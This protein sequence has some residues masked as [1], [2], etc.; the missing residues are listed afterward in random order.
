MLTA[1]G[2]E[3]LAAEA[4]QAGASDYYPKSAIS[5]EILG[6]AIHKS[7]QRS[8]LAN[9]LN[10]A[11]QVI[12]TLAAAVEAKDPTTQG[13]LQRLAFYSVRVG[14]AMNLAEHQ[15]EILR[16]GGIL[17]D[18][19]KMGV[20]E[21]ILR[22]PSSLNDT[23]WEEMRKHPAIGESICT[24]LR[25]ALEVN[26][27]I[28]HHHERWDGGGYPDRLREAEIPLG[29]RIVCAADA[30]DAMATDRPYRNALPVERIISELSAGAGKQF[31]PDVA[32]VL[33]EMISAGTLDYRQAEAALPLPAAIR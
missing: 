7:L 21:S 26:P 17:H 28:R 10:G 18:I 14:Q 9:H 1:G 12:F 2:D 33:I 13:H 31:D 19:G 5:A 20:S 6:H 8:Q 24:T 4:M 30:F 15:L 29:A 27:I 22:K 16:F 32:A 25:N 3:R 11:E 23:E